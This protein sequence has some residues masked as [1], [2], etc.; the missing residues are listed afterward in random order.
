MASSS[1]A[2]IRI[3]GVGFLGMLTVLFVGL[4]LTGHIDWSWLWVLAPLW[5][6]W[7]AVIGL[8]L[9]FAGVVI[10]AGLV[11][12]GCLAIAAVIM[13]IWEARRK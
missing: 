12:T 4:K 2:T 3:P 7:A 8:P 13:A 5:G 10:V 1:S 6:P 9:V 11:A